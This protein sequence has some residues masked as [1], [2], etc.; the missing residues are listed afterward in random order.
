MGPDGMHPQVVKK[1]ADLW[2]TLYYIW[3]AVLTGEGSWELEERKCHLKKGKEEPNKPES[4]T[5]L[6]EKVTK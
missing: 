6:S 2:A 5:S 1:L 4:L 3:K